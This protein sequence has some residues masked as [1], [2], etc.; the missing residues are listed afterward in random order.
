MRLTKAGERVHFKKGDP[1]AVFVPFPRF[2][3]DNFSLEI[4]KSPEAIDEV[5]R[6][7]DA[8]DGVRTMESEKGVSHST[9]RKGYEFTG[10]PF[11]NKHQIKLGYEKELPTE[12]LEFFKEGNYKRK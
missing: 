6:T 11:H 12:N 9:Y 10:C 5:N 4:N 1:L 8:F 3:V 2:F 7:Q